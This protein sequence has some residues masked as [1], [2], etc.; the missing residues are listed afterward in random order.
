[1]NTV[2]IKA[3]KMVM[4]DS[5]HSGTAF[6][7]PQQEQ[8]M[9]HL[10]P[11]LIMLLL[12]ACSPNNP[13]PNHISSNHPVSTQAILKLDTKGHTAKIQDIIV[14]KS[15]DIISASED[16]TIKVWDSV[17]GKET[18]K[19]LGQI[20]AGKE[21][22]IYAMALSPNEEF[23][24]IGGYLV[25]TKVSRERYT[26]RI[27]NYKTGKLSKVLKSHTNVINDLAFSQDGKYLISGSSDKTAKI[28]QMDNFTLI[29]TMKLH[30]KQV[31]AVKIIKKQGRYFTL[32]TGYD[33]QIVLYDMAKQKVV[34]RD[35][36]NY[37]LQYLAISNSHIAVCG[38]SNNI[39]IYDFSLTPIRTIS[40]ETKPAGLAY[41]PS[42]EFLMAGTKGNPNHNVNIYGA[43]REYQKIQ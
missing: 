28:W 25:G 36:K 26:I 23:L 18:R 24:A 35:K 8:T 27:Y 20:G 21:G 7:T 39:T 33:K 15:K 2:K 29:D 38:K 3:K 13:R 40:S 22:K 11:I 16:K 19:I 9:K 10:L 32:T 37:K 4:L 14:T 34:K 17:T 31:Y 6:K 30:T 41:S 5:C 43:K 1:M 42:G 12:T